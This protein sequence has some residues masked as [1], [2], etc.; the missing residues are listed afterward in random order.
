MSQ[1]SGKPPVGTAFLSE[2][3][4]VPVEDDR[5]DRP[6]LA[7]GGDRDLDVVVHVHVVLILWR[8]LT[9]GPCPAAGLELLTEA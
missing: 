3:S 4:A 1:Q 2:G 9:V 5:A 7:V 8:V 6:A